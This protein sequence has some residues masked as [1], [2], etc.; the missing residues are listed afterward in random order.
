LVFSNRLGWIGVDIG[1]HTVKLAQAVRTPDGVRVGHAAV[2]QRPHS[3]PDDDSLAWSPPQKSPVEIRAALECSQFRGRSAACT[4]PM[5]VCELRGLNVPLGDERERR[6]MISNVLADDWTER[7]FS[8]EFDYWELGDG[9]VSDTVDSF[10]VN[11]LSTARPWIA[12]VVDD[13]RHAGLDC[14][15]IDGGPLAVARG[16]AMAAGLRGGQR[17]LA[18]DW[19]FS[20]TTL[21]VVGNGRPLYSR[22]LHECSFRRLLETIQH[23]LGV[24]ADH[25][26]YLADAHGVTDPGDDACE[27]HD[28]QQAITDSV[29][30]LIAEFVEQLQRTLRFVD[31]QRR[32]LRPAEVWL[33]GGGASVR[34]MGPYLS[35]ALDMPVH[36]WGVPC[37]GHPVGV[38]NGTSPLFA[39]AFALSTLA[40]S[41]P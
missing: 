27:I 24:S 16:V 19:G 36:I 14:W 8:I 37:D 18:V 11:V 1:T 10:N 21:C 33:V 15:A 2:I 12:Q 35:R 41:N 32:H 40:W 26:Q 17:A 6:A 34:N 13:C 5:N 20:N 39:G 30:D 4:L 28:I 23:T 3:W 7:E 22:R 9:K 25:A 31:L 38:S 29:A